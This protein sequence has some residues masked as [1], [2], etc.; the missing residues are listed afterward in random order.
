LWR[1]PSLNDS[2]LLISALA[3]LV[4]SRMHSFSSTVSKAEA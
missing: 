1:A 2:G 4:R 3:D